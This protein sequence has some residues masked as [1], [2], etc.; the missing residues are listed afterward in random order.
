[1][2]GDVSFNV[3]SGQALKLSRRLLAARALC[4]GTGARPRESRPEFRTGP[5]VVQRSPLPLPL[6]VPFYTHPHL[7]RPAPSIG[8]RGRPASDTM[9]YWSH[10]ARA[11]RDAPLSTLCTGGGVCESIHRC[12]T[13]KRAGNFKSGAA[14]QPMLEFSCFPVSLASG[15]RSLAVFFGSPGRQPDGESNCQR[16]GPPSWQ[17]RTSVFCF[18]VPVKCR[19]SRCGPVGFNCRGRC[20]GEAPLMK[21][22]LLRI[23]GRLLRVPL[24]LRLL[25]RGGLGDGAPPHRCGC[26]VLRG[27]G[28]LHRAMPPRRSAPPGFTVIEV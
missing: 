20:E 15:P 9:A 24:V 27:Q 11:W 25:R 12:L 3:S 2:D 10:E 6:A 13:W 23:S 18:I 8:P 22:R 1:M 5:S 14:P 4:T 28:G 21:C 19:L 16:P 7:L 26:L 17:S